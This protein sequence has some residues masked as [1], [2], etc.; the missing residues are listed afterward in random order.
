MKRNKLN[1]KD[2][3]RIVNRVLSEQVVNP[4]SDKKNKKKTDVKPRC[5]P[6]NV[7]P[8]SE[9]VGQAD[10]FVKYA[11]G[12]KKRRS[13]V[14]SMVDTLGILNNIRWANDIKDGGAHLAYEMMNHLNRFRNKNYYDETTGDCHKAMNKIAELYKENEHGIELVKDIERVLNLQTKDD[15]FTPSPRAKE[16]LK[17]C[18]NLAKGQ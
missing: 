6:E 10:D 2:V 11:P 17:Q 14:N 13:G 12:I 16:Y 9:I 18:I 5:I 15:E 3:T 4:S 1:E 8:L 7:I